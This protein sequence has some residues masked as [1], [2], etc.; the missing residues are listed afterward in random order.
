MSKCRNGKRIV[1]ILKPNVDKEFHLKLSY[2]TAVKPPH[3]VTV[4]IN[5][6]F[7]LVAAEFCYFAVWLRSV[8]TTATSAEP[9]N[10]LVEKTCPDS[11]ALVCHHVGTLSPCGVCQAELFQHLGQRDLR[12]SVVVRVAFHRDL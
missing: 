1:H 4:L 10:Q 9:R 2:I 6:L 12:G 7:L 8:V 3:D 5:K 11:A